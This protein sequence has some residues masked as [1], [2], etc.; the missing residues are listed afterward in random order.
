MPNRDKITTYSQEFKEQKD[1]RCLHM[2]WR[3]MLVI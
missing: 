3:A 2:I 1:N